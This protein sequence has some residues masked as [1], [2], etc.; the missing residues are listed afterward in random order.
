MPEISTGPPNT[1]P[2]NTPADQLVPGCHQLA[3]LQWV[4]GANTGRETV[5]EAGTAK[6]SNVTKPC[7]R[8]LERNK[9]GK[10]ADRHQQSAGQ[11]RSRNR[12]SRD[13]PAP[14]SQEAEN[15]SRFAIGG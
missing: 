15:L 3:A 6:K 12:H 1:S 14:A 4:V 5:I 10:G 13:M 11:S 7:G 2:S 8:P 9:Q